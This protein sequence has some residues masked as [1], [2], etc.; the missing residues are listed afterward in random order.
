MVSTYKLAIFYKNFSRF[1]L[2]LYALACNIILGLF[3]SL[4]CK[5][6]FFAYQS[7]VK[8][9]ILLDYR[10]RMLLFLKCIKKQIER[11][12]KNGN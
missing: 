1:L 2:T 4:V 12:K 11:G 6:D 8:M 9:V 10:T 3:E 7:Y 5:N